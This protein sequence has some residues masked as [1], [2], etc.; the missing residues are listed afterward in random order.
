MA[1]TTTVAHRY[2]S[3]AFYS[4]Q[5]TNV[6][7]MVKPPAPPPVANGSICLAGV[8]MVQPP[9]ALGIVAQ[10]E[11]GVNP[12]LR[13]ACR[14]LDSGEWN[15]YVWVV[16]ASPRAA[17]PAVGASAMLR[18]ARSTACEPCARPVSIQTDLAAPRTFSVRDWNAT[19]E[20]PRSE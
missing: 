12:P 4:S 6:G 3:A 13:A 17:S 20:T 15:G 14:R 8:E 10:P 1:L 5:G 7:V 18:P 9:T 2:R 11:F 16:G 19:H